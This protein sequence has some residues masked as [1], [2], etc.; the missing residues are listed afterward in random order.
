MVL[1]PLAWIEI[2]RRSAWGSA[3]MLLA[4]VL[5]VPLLCVASIAL[6]LMLNGVIGMAGLQ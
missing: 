1:A 2:A 5:T 3:R 6:S 4:A